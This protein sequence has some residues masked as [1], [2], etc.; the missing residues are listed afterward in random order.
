[1]RPAAGLRY[2]RTSQQSDPFNHFPYPVLQEGNDNVLPRIAL[3]I[4]EAMSEELLALDDF[5]ALITHLKVKPLQW[6]VH[7][8]RQVGWRSRASG[9]GLRLRSEVAEVA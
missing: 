1:M 5:E 9:S 6:K 7:K 4:M 2:T 3:S 8:Y